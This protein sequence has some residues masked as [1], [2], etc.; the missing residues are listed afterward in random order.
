[1]LSKVGLSDDRVVVGNV[2]INDVMM[3]C[4]TDSAILES[5]ISLVSVITIVVMWT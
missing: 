4:V 3:M 1:M 5:G 2:C